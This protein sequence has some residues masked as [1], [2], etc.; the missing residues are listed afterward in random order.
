MGNI[1]KIHELLDMALCIQM[2][3]SGEK[4]HPYVKFTTSNFAT[5]V[6]IM[7][8]DSGF[9]SD[10]YDGEYN[11]AFDEMD[12]RTYRNC[13]DHLQDLINIIKGEA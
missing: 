5:N 8:K 4:D 6:E 1:E 3:G 10:R 11:L 7:I 13:K 2:H 12:C 9:D